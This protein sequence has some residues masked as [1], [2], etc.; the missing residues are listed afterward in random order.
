MRAIDAPEQRQ[1]PAA[2]AAAEFLYLDQS[3]V[4][5]AGVLD[6]PAAMEAVG[7]AFAQYDLGRCKQPYKVVLRNGE[8]AA[9]EEFGR[10]NGLFAIIG[11]PPAAMGMKWIGSFPHN[12]DRG[13]PRASALVILN[14][15]ETGFPIAIMDATLISAVRTGAVTALGSMFLAPK[16][17]QKIGVVGAGVQARTQILGL[18]TALPTVKQVAI[19]NRT[20]E[21]AELLAEECAR[22][23]NAPTVVANSIEEALSDADVTLT[24]TTALKPIVSG[25]H[26]K[27][28]A[29]TIQLAGHECEFDLI[30]QCT[31]IVVDDWEVLKHRGIISPAVMHA[32]GLLDDS[33]IYAT[34]GELI[35]GKKAGRESDSERIHFAHMGMGIA[36][37]ALAFSV[38]RRA[39]AMG[40]GQT[41]NLWNEPLWS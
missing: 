5:A 8:D 14:S 29:L 25:K 38:Y 7:D 3:A 37:V 20:Q 32:Q 39:R 9:C 22:R 21:H 30:Q 41:L 35:R 36:D 31:K 24:I 17:A 13:L 16:G 2:P 40:L 33:A 28:G 27:P 23:W 1:T 34:L 12:R 26:I 10:F 19:Y 18:I 15:P 11:D 4:V 6:M